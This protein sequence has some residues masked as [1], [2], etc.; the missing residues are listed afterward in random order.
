MTLYADLGVDP[1]A[2]AAAIRAAYRSAAQKHHPDK[3][4]EGE[5]FRLIQI[6]YDVLGDAAKRA[7]Y[8]T[9]G[10]TSSG[11]TVRSRAL[12]SIPTM[13]AQ[14]MDACDTDTTDILAAMVRGV[15]H[16]A[17]EGQRA[18]ATL[19]TKVKKRERALKR[20]GVIEGKPNLVASAIM[21]A[22]GQMNQQAAA[23]RDEQEVCAEMLVILADHTYTLDP[24]SR[25][26]MS[27]M[28]SS[29]AWA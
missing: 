29:S 27:T 20:L 15:K 16:I 23:H 13:L 21:A 24:V 7:R 5:Q 1:D 26:T 22:I 18:E 25:P 6:A 12:A 11:P 10:D 14:V 9:T 2:D 8:D 19:L 3:G 17:D 4:G 28:W